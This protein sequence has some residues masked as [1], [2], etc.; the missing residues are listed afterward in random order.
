MT[1]ESNMFGES[2]AARTK[3]HKNLVSKA[4]GESKKSGR[5]QIC[6]SLTQEEHAKLKAHAEQ[7]GATVSGLIKV[8]IRDNC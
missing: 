7:I 5:V 6:V 8:W 1:T 2:A 3:E 4:T